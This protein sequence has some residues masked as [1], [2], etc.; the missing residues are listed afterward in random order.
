MIAAPQS[1][2]QGIPGAGRLPVD[3]LLL[4]LGTPAEPTAAALRPYLR[5]FL[6]DPRVIE[7]SPLLRWV[8]VN[9]IIVPLR[10]RRSAAKYRRIWDP[11]RGSPL[12]DVTRRQA[13]ALAEK[14]GAGFRVRFAMRYG[15][16]STRSVLREMLAD[17]CKRLIEAEQDG[18]SPDV[19]LLSFHGIPKSY[20]DRGDPYERQ[21]R[22]TAALIARRMR[23]SDDRWRLTFQSRL[24]PTEWLRPYTDE[25]LK[26]LGADGV[27][28]VLVATP[29]FTADC[30]E[31]IDE[32]GYEGLEE[33]KGAGGGNLVRVPCLNDGPE[34]IEAL[35]EL[36]EREAGGWR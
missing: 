1:R 33:F 4:Q 31:T 30:L 24:G 20:V 3:V 14:L 23:W 19:C 16:P 36:V 26:Q 2:E 10:A 15:D 35:T 27:E 7:T 13:A 21:S 8:L 32:I 18:L 22:A 25:T 11:E 28:T 12:L 34:F 5:E 9:L 29:G 17:G 6:S